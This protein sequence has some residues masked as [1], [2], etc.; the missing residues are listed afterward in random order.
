[1]NINRVIIENAKIKNA[2]GSLVV[3]VTSTFLTIKMKQLFI[4]RLFLSNLR[5]VDVQETVTAKI[6]LQQ[7]M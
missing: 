3:R 6:F 1:M 2:A 5:I 7:S 4:V